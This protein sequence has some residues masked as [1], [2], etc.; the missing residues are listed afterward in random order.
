MKTKLHI[1]Y[2]VGRGLGPAFVCPLIDYSVSGQ[3]Q[4]SRLVD[5]IGLPVEFLSPTGSEILLSIFFIR[6]PNFHPLF[7][8]G[9][10]YLSQLLGGASQRTAM[11]DTCYK[12][13]RYH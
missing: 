3:G 10:L 8:C 5:S 13:N 1:C 12:H 9:C 6:V 11:L 2:T 7:Y 4:G